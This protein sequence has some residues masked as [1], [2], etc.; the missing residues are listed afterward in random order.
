MLFVETRHAVDPETAKQFDTQHLRKNFCLSGMFARGDIRLTYTHYDRLIA[1]GAVP[2]GKDLVLAK[3]AETGTESVL[4][5]REMTIVNIGPPGSVK[6]GGQTYDM[7][8]GDMLYIGMGQGEIIFS[9]TGRYYILSAPAHKEYP[10]RL[11]TISDSAKV[12]LGSEGTSNK[13]TIFQYVHPLVMT[14]CQL[15]VGMTKLAPGSVWNTMPAHTHDR[16]SE[17]YLYFDLSENQNVMHLMGEPKQ[18]RHLILR[19][20]EGA[21]S[22][23]WSIHS[24]AGTSAYSFIWAMAGDNID[25]T[26]MDMVAMGELE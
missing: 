26:D 8:S 1:G 9:G 10:T 15:I 13:R 7:A 21:V 16:R 25:F 2:D 20:E 18:T 22:P 4:D 3:V 17:I 12:E 24:G 14:S 5:R 6:A 11:V 19:N 23:P